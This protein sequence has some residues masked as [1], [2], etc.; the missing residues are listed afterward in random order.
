[1][2]GN[3]KQTQATVLSVN[4]KLIALLNWGM[5]VFHIR[6]IMTY[7][8]FPWNMDLFCVLDQFSDFNCWNSEMWNILCIKSIFQ[9]VNYS[10]FPS[11][12]SWQHV[13]RLR[14]NRRGERESVLP[15]IESDKE[16]TL[17]FSQLPSSDWWYMLKETTPKATKISI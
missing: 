13:F 7:C 6:D 15:V 9:Y 14:L 10:P 12:S 16:A 5:G 1:M 11:S 2:F 17:F 4:E 3:K 8:K